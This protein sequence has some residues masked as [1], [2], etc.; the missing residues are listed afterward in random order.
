MMMIFRMLCYNFL[1]ASSNNYQ[2]PRLY[3]SGHAFAFKV[4]RETAEEIQSLQRSLIEKEAELL[5]A[6]K[7]KEEI[8]KILKAHQTRS[9]V[10]C[11][12]RDELHSD[13]IKVCSNCV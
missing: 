7:A 10:E 1:Y 3:C 12:Q 8:D 5:S 13:T 2:S 11:Q 9:S 4:K 6:N